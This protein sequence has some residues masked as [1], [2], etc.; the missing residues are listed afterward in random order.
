MITIERTTERGTFDTGGKFISPGVTQIQ[1]EGRIQPGPDKVI[2]DEEGRRN[3]GTITIYTN[4]GLQTSNVKAGTKA[5]IVIYNNKRYEI[6]EVTD[7]REDSLNP[8]VMA[9]ANQEAP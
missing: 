1:I 9:M 4:E 3:I 7:W 2:V 8:H 6:D 5:D